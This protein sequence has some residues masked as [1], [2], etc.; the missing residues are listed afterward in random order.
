MAV[1]E[2]A[3]KIVNPLGMHARPAAELVKV[4]NRFRSKVEVRKDDLAVNGKSILGVMMLAAECGSSLTITTDGDDAGEAMEALLAL[5]A[6]GFHEMH[7]TQD[8]KDAE[9]RDGA[10]DEEEQVQ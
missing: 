3:A 4:A 10:Q 2:R 9:L 7:L 6:D 1:I 5:V 8:A